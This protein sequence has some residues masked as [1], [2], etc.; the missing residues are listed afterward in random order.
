MKSDIEIAQ[1]NEMCPI[2]NILSQEKFGLMENNDFETYGPFKAKVTE[3]G[4]SFCNKL[5]MGKL[6]LVTAISPTPAGEGKTTTTIGLVDGLNRLGV[7]AV[8]ALREPSMGPVFGMKGGACGGGYAQVQPMEDINLH[9]MGDFHAITAANNLLCAL[10][11]NELR[12]EFCEIIPSSIRVKRCLDVNDRELR[13][14]VIGL[15]GSAHGVPRE[16]HFQIT[17]ASEIMAIL[18][19]AKDLNDLKYRIGNIIIGE[20]KEHKPLLVK[21]FGFD[22]AITALLKDAIRPNFVQT[23]EH[24]LAII[25]GGPFANIAHG[26]NSIRA[27]KL[28]MQLGD[29][30]VTEAGFGA[31]LGAEK[32]IDIKCREARIFTNCIVLVATIRALKYHGGVNKEDLNISNV[33]ALTAGFTE[34]LLH[35]YIN[36]RKFGVPVVVAFNVFESDSEEEIAAVK[37]LCNKFDLK[38]AFNSSFANGGQGAEELAQLVSDNLKEVEP[39]FLYSLDAPLHEKLQVLA[40]YYGASGVEFANS[41]VKA[42]AFELEN[43][44][45][46]I[47]VAKTQYSFSDDPK[48]FKLPKDFKITVSDI[49]LSN[50][51][52]FIVIYLGDILTMPGLPDCPAALNINI[53]SKGKIKGLF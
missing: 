36:L 27:T 38:L 21:Q 11:D 5:A 13:N 2:K 10:V 25:H 30:A 48:K 45:L 12:F 41:R 28:A 50:G 20:D 9:F 31:D 29:V 49:S 35:H 4:I 39:N 14:C 32:F 51:A 47:C 33:I 37:K 1:E 34:N 17:V 46:P 7:G 24:N 23:L 19:L 53:D 6:V 22:G 52:G 40:R 3:N 8:A 42:K 16:E 18:C 15:G 43:V 44:S 26:C